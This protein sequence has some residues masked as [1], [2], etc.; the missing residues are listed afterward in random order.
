ME[1]AKCH[2]DDVLLLRVVTLY[3][4]AKLGRDARLS[5]EKNSALLPTVRFLM[6][7]PA[8][9]Q[10]MPEVASFCPPKAFLKTKH[11]V[12]SSELA[13]WAPGMMRE[14]AR[15][16]TVNIQKRR[17][18][19]KALSWQEHLAQGHVGTALSVRE[20]RQGIDHIELKG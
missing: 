5:Q 20:Q 13:R 1:R 16:I 4:V 15:S 17:V 18:T 10:H 11:E 19:M 14:I 3:V 8:A 6:E 12:S 9:P 7:Q 2:L